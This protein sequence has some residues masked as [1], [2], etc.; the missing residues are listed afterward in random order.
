MTHFGYLFVRKTSQLTLLIIIVQDVMP[1][2]E[3]KTQT[4]LEVITYIGV[5]VSVICL[6]IT[7]VT[8][9]GSPR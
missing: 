8:Y 1:P 5:I 2:A 6:I 9:I 4:A 3:P 7:I